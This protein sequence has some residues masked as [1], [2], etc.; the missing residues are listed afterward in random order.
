M[1]NEIMIA[2]EENIQQDQNEGIPVETVRSL[3]PRNN[4]PNYYESKI[5]R[6]KLRL[7]TVNEEEPR[8]FNE[9]MSR[10]D[11]DQWSK[12]MTEELEA[13]YKNNV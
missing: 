2:N 13:L 11:K 10:P 4:R 3:R 7:T 5:G 8:D 6:P 1:N 12:A 9:A